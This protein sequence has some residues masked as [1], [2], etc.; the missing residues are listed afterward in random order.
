MD[1]SWAI[2][3]YN[4]LKKWKKEMFDKKVKATMRQH[5]EQHKIE[6]E[7]ELNRR[8]RYRLRRL[9]VYREPS[10]QNLNYKFIP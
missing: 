9:K 3:I 7:L 10:S 5:F 4:S 8:L 1:W 2:N 6:F